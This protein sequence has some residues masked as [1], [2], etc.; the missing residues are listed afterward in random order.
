MASH[1]V[2]IKIK[3]K[4][5][6]SLSWYYAPC[7]KSHRHP[8]DH[9]N[10]FQIHLTSLSVSVSGTF[11]KYHYGGVLVSLFEFFL[12]RLVIKK[13]KFK[14]CLLVFVN[15]QRACKYIV[16]CHLQLRLSI[17]ILRKKLYLFILCCNKQL[18][19]ESLNCCIK[20]C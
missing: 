11:L 14:R 9:L 17:K 12:D 6:I 10:F 3:V 4:F 15:L 18:V 5:M 16:I 1:N 13:F 7:E 8:D 19:K 2:M 20:N